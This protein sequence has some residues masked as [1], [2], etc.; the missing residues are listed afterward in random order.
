ML[1]NYW[2]KIDNIMKRIVIFIGI[3]SLFLGLNKELKAQ[4]C[5]MPIVVH[6]SESIKTLP[7]N[8]DSYLTNLLNRIVTKSGMG[9]DLLYTQ[10]FITAHIDVLNKDVVSG[11]P[12]QVVQNLGVSFYIGD[13][14][15]KKIFSSTYIE[16]NGV[17]SNETKSIINALQRLNINHKELIKFI[18]EGNKQILAYYD[19]SYSQIIARANQLAKMQQYEEALSL[20]VPI[21]PCSKGYEEAMQKGLDIY[22][23]YMNKT[24]LSLLNQARIQWMKN[25]TKEGAAEAGRYLAS[26]DAEATCYLEAIELYKEIKNKIHDDLNFEMRTKYTDEIALKKQLIESLRD[27]GVAYGNGQQPV[28]TNVTWVK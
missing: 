11:S 16:V 6:L 28:T 8:I 24:A 1:I 25:Q 15:N 20:I 22:Q 5:E 4:K 19:N 7:V 13:L 9:V 10:F 2:R 3:I 26:I 23:K 21:P 17:G 12:I 18:E 14:L 27:V